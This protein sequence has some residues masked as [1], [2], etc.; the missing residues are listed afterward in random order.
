MTA[1]LPPAAQRFQ[2]ALAAEGLD[3]SVQIM[4]ATTRTSAEAAA[5]IGC[6]VG[7]IAKSLI[8]R[9]KQSGKAVLVIASGANRVDEKAVRAVIGEKI[10]KA[11]AA[12][13]KE[14]TGFAIGGVPPFGHQTESVVVI[15]E[16]LMTLREIWAA[17]GTPFAVFPSTPDELVRAT[18]GIVAS[19]AKETE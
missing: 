18:G 13:V 4:P 12:F 14:T 7:Q 9:G 2:E 6:E 1:D 15:D 17:G 5:A 8:F 11:D 3:R 10:G 19:I 16:D